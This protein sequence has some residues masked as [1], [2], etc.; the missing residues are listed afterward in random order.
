MDDPGSA[1]RID[2]AIGREEA[3]FFGGAELLFGFRHLPR[4]R[5]T[6]AV[7]ICSPLLAD[8]RKNYRREVL[9]GRRLAAEGIAVQRF[10]YRGAGGHSDGNP[11]DVTFETLVEDATAA[12]SRL[13][14]VTGVTVGAF[15][16]TRVG[17][18]VAARV[19]AAHDG[20]ALALWEPTS[21]A[22]AYYREGFRASAIRALRQQAPDAGPSRN[23]I[24][25]LRTEGQVDILGHSVCRNLY[26]S[27]Q[28]LDLE[29]ELDRSHGP[30]ALIQIAGSDR[31]RRAYQQLVD[32]LRSQN[33]PVVAHAV[34]A[35]VAWWLAE[36][37]GNDVI[38]ND[39]SAEV[40][41]LTQRWLVAMVQRASIS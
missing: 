27:L 37:D 1:V 29:R 33:R 10:H 36:G 15:V 40:V 25:I 2:D 18:L 31:L 35:E 39:G 17:A 20:A 9:L 30:I 19:A 6:S 32:M 5:P 4:Q 12:A 8:F 16:G 41:E 13:V 26:D 23:Q 21:S 7:V 28:S 14:E 22:E 3:E 34:N 24:H 38:Q 11:D